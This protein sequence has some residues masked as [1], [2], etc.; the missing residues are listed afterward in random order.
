[1]HAGRFGSRISR[2]ARLRRANHY[3]PGFQ[4]E[5][6]TCHPCLRRRPGS[7]QTRRDCLVAVSPT[8]TFGQSGPCRS[9]GCPG[10]VRAALVRQHARGRPRLSCVPRGRKSL[11]ATRHSQRTPKQRARGAPRPGPAFAGRGGGPR[12]P[13]GQRSSSAVGGVTGKIRGRTGANLDVTN[14]V[15]HRCVQRR[16]GACEPAGSGPWR[17]RLPSRCWC[18]PGPVAPAGDGQMWEAAGRG[19]DLFVPA[20]TG[21]QSERGCDGC[22]ER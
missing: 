3:N 17:R 15:A 6:S 7:W 21:Y 9:S 13:T 12:F 8:V 5:P 16:C 10:P 1:M 4:P 20:P 18:G 11:A 19:R 22:E 14:N 2:K